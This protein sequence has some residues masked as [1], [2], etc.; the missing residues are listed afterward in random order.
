MFVPMTDEDRARAVA[1]IRALFVSYIRNHGIRREG[2][3]TSPADRESVP[4]A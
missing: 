4:E 3:P 1:A 2:A